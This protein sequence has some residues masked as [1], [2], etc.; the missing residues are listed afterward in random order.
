MEKFE[1]QK[2]FI[3][4]N[5]LLKVL[6]WAESGAQANQIIEEGLVKVNNHI[7]TRKRNKLYD[8]FTITF[9][10]QTIQLIAAL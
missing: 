8:G 10:D 7:E 4:L 6:G 5:Q 3:L 9:E 2:E 1:L